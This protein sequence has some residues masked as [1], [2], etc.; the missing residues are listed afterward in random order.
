M[1]K[2]PGLEPIDYLIIGHITQDITPEGTRLGGTASFSGLTALALGARVGVVTA[3]GEETGVEL[4]EGLAIV[5]QKC[6]RSSTFENVYT[7][8]GRLQTLH[9]IAPNLDYYHIPEVWRKAPIVHLA[10]VIQEINPNIV[11]YFPDSQIYVTP[12]GWLRGWDHQGGLHRDEWPEAR[13]ILRQTSAVVISQEDVENDPSIIEMMA[14]AAPILVVTQAADGATLYT[15]GE[16]HQFPAPQVEVQDPTGAGDI[17]AAAFF[18]Q[19]SYQGDPREAVLFANQLAANSVTRQ[20]LSSVP[21][22]EILYNQI[23]KSASP[24]D[25]I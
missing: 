10:P 6:E 7:P 24:F 22:E 21:T 4:L 1:L 13:Y 12:Q 15:E 18:L 25:S 16:V 23:E 19:L 17:F 20:G 9:H 5:N 3:W 8:D 14:E 11:R 2:V